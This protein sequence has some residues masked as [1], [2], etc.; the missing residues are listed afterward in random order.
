MAAVEE[1]SQILGCGHRRPVHVAAILSLIRVRFL[2]PEVT[3]FVAVALTLS[4]GSHTFSL[5]SDA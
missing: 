5:P 2:L 3:F 4:F 1:H